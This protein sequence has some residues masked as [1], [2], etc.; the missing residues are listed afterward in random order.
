ML[1]SAKIQLSMQHSLRDVAADQA[2]IARSALLPSLAAEVSHTQ[3]D[4]V[5]PIRCC[6]L[7]APPGLGQRHRLPLQRQ[8]LGR[9]VMLSRG[10]LTTRP[11]GT[12]VR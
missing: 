2:R 12:R 6:S 11:P 9:L 5:T 10:S 4:A 1:P 3:I 7:N 8:R